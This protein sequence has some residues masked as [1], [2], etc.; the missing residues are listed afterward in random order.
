M[1]H[2]SHHVIFTAIDVPLDEVARN[3]IHCNSEIQ[4][5]YGFISFEEPLNW[6]IMSYNSKQN[7]G[8]LLTGEFHIYY[9]QTH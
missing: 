7:K 2:L 8:S 3:K 1:S 9:L 6:I 4:L 5:Q